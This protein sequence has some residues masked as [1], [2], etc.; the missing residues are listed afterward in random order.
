MITILKAEDIE[1]LVGCR[2]VGAKFNEG[3]A[4]LTLTVENHEEQRQALEISAQAG[5][6]F[7]GG[8]MQTT[9][10]LVVKTLP[11]Q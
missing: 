11:P 1:Q 8:G 4:S 5:L 3:A 6:V 7:S 9:R 2:I 10:S